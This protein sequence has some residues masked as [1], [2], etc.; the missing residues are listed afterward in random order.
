MGY[1]TSCTDEESVAGPVR[2]KC[3]CVGPGMC[4][5]AHT[6]SQVFGDIAKQF[7]RNA[8]ACLKCCYEYQGGGGGTKA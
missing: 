8:N 4:K 5:R 7:L 2:A 3:A 1:G 6:L